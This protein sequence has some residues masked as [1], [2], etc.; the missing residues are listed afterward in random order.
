MK[1]DRNEMFHKRNVLRSHAREFA[2]DIRLTRELFIIA[3]VQGLILFVL[4]EFLVVV[5]LFVVAHDVNVVLIGGDTRR[6]MRATALEML[7]NGPDRLFPRGRRPLSFRRDHCGQYDSLQLIDE[8]DGEG[9]S[10]GLGCAVI[11]VPHRLRV[12]CHILHA[13]CGARV[14]SLPGRKSG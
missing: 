1:N 14:E 4:G 8:W 10:A 5:I 2:R 11:M 9:G 7:L 12:P 3:I 6:L 13:T